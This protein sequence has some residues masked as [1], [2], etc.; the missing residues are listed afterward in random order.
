MICGSV[1][2]MKT[3]GVIGFY[4]PLMMSLQTQKPTLLN[5]YKGGWNT[6]AKEWRQFLQTM[7]VN[8]GKTVPDNLVLQTMKTCLDKT[9]QLLLENH[10]ERNPHLTIQDFWDHLA[11]LYDKDTK[12]NTGNP[13]KV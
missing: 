4:H 9:D 6:F 3:G 2:S 11:S 12:H 7:M 8:V 10:L 13:G 1:A 5:K